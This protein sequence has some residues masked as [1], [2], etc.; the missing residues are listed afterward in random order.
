MRRHVG[1]VKRGPTVS[2]TREQSKGHVFPSGLLLHCDGGLC[3]WNRFST[4]LEEEGSNRLSHKLCQP[5]ISARIRLLHA[6]LNL[7]HR[8]CSVNFLDVPNCKPN[9]MPDIGQARFH[10]PGPQMRIRFVPTGHMGPFLDDTTLVI[11]RCGILLKKK[12]PCSWAVVKK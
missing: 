1:A 7:Y 9:S 12:Q 2:A 11:N 5:L 6:Y 3:V 4:L 8:S 10:R